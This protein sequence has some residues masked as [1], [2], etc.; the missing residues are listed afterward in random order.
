MNYGI[1]KEIIKQMADLNRIDIVNTVPSYLRILMKNMNKT[2]RLRYVILGGEVLPRN[3]Y[4]ELL[5]TVEVEQ[6]INLYGP[7]ETT[8][9]ATYHI[10]S[11]LTT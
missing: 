5:K 9:N 10:W 3:L 1:K 7:T 8:I 2:H 4:E 6:V 11:L